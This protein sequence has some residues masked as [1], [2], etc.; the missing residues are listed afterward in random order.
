LL[1]GIIGLPIMAATGQVLDGWA[2]LTYAGAA[3]WIA[4]FITETIADRQ[5]GAYIRLSKRPKVLQTGLWRYSRHPNYFGE[6]VQWW[7]IAVIALQASYGWIGLI[8]PAVLTLL[9]LF[10]SGIPPIE[11]RRA[12][13]AAYRTYQK[14]TSAFIPLPPKKS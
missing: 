3:I 11:K 5:L 7:G 4:G 12:K 9:I 2:W 8:G 6:V 13:D 14:Q 10:V 1:I